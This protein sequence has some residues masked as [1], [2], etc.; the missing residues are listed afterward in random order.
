V[1][2]AEGAAVTVAAA[3]VGAADGVEGV[4][5]WTGVQETR[6]KIA[7]AKTGA[8]YFIV[9]LQRWDCRKLYAVPWMTG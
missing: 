3:L 9:V 8:M 2:V 1:L 4:G 5:V 7:A 6:T